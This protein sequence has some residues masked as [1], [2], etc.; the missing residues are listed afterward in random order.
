MR[1]CIIIFYF[2]EESVLSVAVGD[3]KLPN[4]TSESQIEVSQP[5]GL[6]SLYTVEICVFV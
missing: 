5:P 2:I 6:R 1:L 3:E 4:M